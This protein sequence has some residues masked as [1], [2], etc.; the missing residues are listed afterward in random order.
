M[1]IP[2]PEYPRPQ[3]CRG[4]NS[5]LNLN[6]SWE[7]AFDF[8]SSGRE[9][10]LWEQP[11]P[12]TITVPFCP[13]SP[14][15]GIG[16]TDFI[17]AVWYRR[18]IALSPEQLGGRVMLRFG[19]VDYRCTVWVNGRE[20]GS[21]KGGYSS[22]AFDITDLVRAGENELVVLAEDDLRSGRQPKGK[23]AHR[24]RSSGCDYTRTTGIWQTVWLEF[25]PRRHIVSCKVRPQP[26]NG[27]AALTLA[28]AGDLEGCILRAGV[29][30]RGT[31]MGEVT[32]RAART[33]TLELPLAE[34][35]LWEVGRP[36]LYDLYLTLEKEGEHLDEVTGYFGLRTLSWEGKAVL[37]NGRPVFQRLILDQGFY[38]DGIYTAPDDEALRR[39]ILL[40][41][42]LG[43]NGAR[44][45]QKIFEERYLYWA[46]H[47]GYLVW[48]EM[49][50]WGLDITTAA[51]LESFL[52]EWLEE[53]ERDFNH[54]AIVGW[55]PFN[56]TW[57]DPKTGCRQD[58][59][60]L[61][62]VYLATKAA[63]PTRP[64]IDTSGNFHVVTD[65]Y[66]IHDYEQDPEVFRAKF[67]PMAEGGPAYDNFP[68]RQ[69]YRGQPYLVSEYGGTW[70][71]PSPKDGDN[72][73]YGNRPETEEEVLRRFTG[74]TAALLENPAVCGLCYTQLTDV[75][76]EQ[77]GLYAYDRG[78]KFSDRV[79]QGIREVL[80]APAAIEG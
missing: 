16:Y 1:S 80:S 15:S 7:F 17:P 64:V 4:E 51:G 63:D 70:W 32:R 75:E 46:D 49:A 26:E 72:W 59:E 37:L 76:Q 34:T 54:P 31:P 74:L 62:T 24:Y 20:A 18:R 69:Q 60:V 73:G 12:R 9:R 10:R 35:H 68:K 41:M 3:F 14:L 43:F 57:D 66:D 40:A 55:C 50:S 65:L 13:E 39:D 44:L 61:R 8:G 42:E 58:D 27:S 56:E 78:R 53:L 67:A 19:A 45:H 38:P 48:G 29:A 79:Y 25:L 30:Y 71:N 77:N 11:F 33:L 52:P 47:L 28:L 21:H 23:Q 22:F 36:E 5:W 6:G 2:R